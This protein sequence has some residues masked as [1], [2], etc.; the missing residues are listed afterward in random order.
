MLLKSILAAC[1]VLSLSGG[2][3]QL[4]DILVKYLL[5]LFSVAL[6]SFAST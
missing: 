2:A 5:V 6:V 3:G 4:V 1:L